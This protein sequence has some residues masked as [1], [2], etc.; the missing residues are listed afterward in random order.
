[1]TAAARRAAAAIVLILT[2]AAAHAAPAQPPK[3]VVLIVVDQMRGDYVARYGS[4]WIGGLRRLVDGGAWFRRAA[5]PYL[6]TVTCVG[7]ATVSTGA[8]PRTH[9]LVGNAWFDRDLGRSTGC[10]FDPGLTTISYAS[11]VAGGEGPSRLRA[12]TLSDELRAQLPVPARVVTMSIKERTAITLAGL[13]ADAATWFNPAAGG[14]VTS[15]AYTSAPVPFVAAFTKANPVTADLGKV[16]TRMLPAGRYLFADAGRG[17][18][19]P[20]FW[21]AGFPHALEAKGEVPDAQFF[22]AWESSPFSDDYLGRLAIASV[23][24]LK[25]GQGTGTDFLGISFSALDLVGHDFGPTSHEVQDTL[26]RL[27]RTIGA[28]LDHLDRTAGAGNYVV[29]LTA[30]HGVAPIPEQ[31]AA[32]GIDAG[33]LDAALVRQAAQRALEAALGPGTYTVRSQ[34]SDLILEPDAVEQLRRDPRA[35]DQ[36]LRAL[37]A[38]PGVAA[39][40]FAEQLDAYAAAGDRDARAALLG[41]YPGRSGDVIVMP[42]P[43]WFFVAADGTA[44]PGSATSHGTMYGY[45][46]QVPII[47]FGKGIKPGEYARVV[48]PADIAPTLAFLCGVTLAH[49]DGEILG[50][51][52][53]PAAPAVRRER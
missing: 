47:L 48:T 24:A 8:F 26:A 33:R 44:Q 7:H 1:M 29:A 39:A 17:E 46:Q 22:E 49:A 6:T 51:A 19:P 15:S 13:R 10:T 21:S 5:Y 9:G 2:A 53:G 36:V 25:L 23:D 4:Q 41:Y 40:F 3:L 35:L 42:H 37:R 31:A 20:A 16:W 38:V 27:D 28:L 52:L 43:Y 12:A 34:Y 11:P 30:D 32:F 45:D 14:F 50:E 18:K